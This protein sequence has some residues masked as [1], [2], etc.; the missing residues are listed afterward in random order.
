[1][2]EGGNHGGGK[3]E[4]EEEPHRL[5][6]M[7]AL[8]REDPGA[9]R[10]PINGAGALRWPATFLAP[11]PT[12]SSFGLTSSPLGGAGTGLAGPMRNVDAVRPVPRVWEALGKALGGAAKE[13]ATGLDLLSPSCFTDV[14]ALNSGL[15]IGGAAAAICSLNC[16]G[17]CPACMASK[18]LKA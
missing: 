7:V 12:P 16:G 14:S 5:T 1:M 10:F 4:E 15:F 6:L 8:W 11:D 2:M 9:P 13:P 18:K 3:D 17:T